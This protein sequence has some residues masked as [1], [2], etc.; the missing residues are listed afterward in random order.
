MCF[1]DGMSIASMP[2]VQDHKLAYEGDK[3]PNTGGMGT[4]SDA[5]HLLPFLR[6]EDVDDALEITR[7]VQ[8]ALFKETGALFKGIMYGG[9]IATRNGVKLIEFNARFGDPEVMN[10]L[11]ILKTNFVDICLAIIDGSLSSLN[12]EFENKA[13]VCKYIVP[14]GYPSDPLKGEVISIDEFP[15]NSEM[16]FASVDKTDE[17]LKM[18]GSRAI[19]FVGIGDSIFDAEEIA[20]KAC[21]H[22]KGKVF[23]RKDIGTKELVSK[24]V[25]FMKDL[26]EN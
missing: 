26:Y 14:E 22:V 13:T 7:L 4:Y 20:E 6:Q 17:G 21:L 2:A 19:A 15:T 10:V 3:G 25:K 1:S 18:S 23:H 16:F 9:F 11:S 12:I 5:N 8:K 24:K